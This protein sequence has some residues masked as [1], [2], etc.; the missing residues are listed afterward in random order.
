MRPQAVKL[1]ATGLILLWLAVQAAMLIM[2]GLGHGGDT[3]RYLSSGQQIATGAMPAGKAASYMSYNLLVGG[4]LALGLG[5]GGVIAAQLLASA[6]A[7]LCM[8]RVASRMWHQ[9]T[10]LLAAFMYIAFLKLHPWNVFILTDSLFISFVIITTYFLTEAIVQK[11]AIYIVGLALSA[12]YAIFLRPDGLAI[13]ASLTLLGLVIAIRKK[14]WRPLI[15]IFALALLLAPSAWKFA[16]QLASHEFLVAHYAQGAVIWNYE[17]FYLDMPGELPAAIQPSQHPLINLGYFAADKPLYF[18]KLSTIKIFLFAIHIRPYHSLTHN[19]LIVI[20]LAVLYPAAILTIKNNPGRYPLVSLFLVS[21]FLSKAVIAGA[22][23][24]DWSGRFFLHVIP[25][26]L[27]LASPTIVKVS[28]M[29]S[30]YSVKL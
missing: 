5:E 12:A 27:L 11:K 6:I 15:V 21:L 20:W 26:L 4:S 22:T 16:G 7:A 19:L 10:G 17:P 9:A 30:R 25:A 2:F 18:L 1:A 29:H 14:A 13:L 3:G 24:A 28:M 23:F 8:Y